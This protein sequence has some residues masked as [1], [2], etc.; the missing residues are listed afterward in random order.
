M[1]SA[2]GEKFE[3]EEAPCANV[4]DFLPMQEGL[5]TLFC[6][7]S[8]H[9]NALTTVLRQPETVVWAGQ[10]TERCAIYQAFASLSGDKPSD[11]RCSSCCSSSHA[12]RS[13]SNMAV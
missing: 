1:Q 10:R 5:R 7:P 8:L 11:G 12:F 6:Q 13:P 4:E 9:A 3:D 2:H